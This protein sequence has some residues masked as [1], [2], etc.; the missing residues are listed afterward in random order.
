MK[1][2]EEQQ[3]YISRS[4][5]FRLL[6]KY[7]NHA[8]VGNL[9]RLRRPKKLSEDQLVLIDESLAENNE[10]TTRQL[11]LLLQEWWPETVVLLPTI[12]WAWKVLDGLLR[13]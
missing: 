3:L 9:P 8:T 11:C 7:K 13:G 5:I 12:K 2:L 10:L 6:W 1:R 4:A